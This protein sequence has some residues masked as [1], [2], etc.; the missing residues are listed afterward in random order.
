M[1]HITD[2]VREAQQGFAD[3]PLNRVDALVFSWLAN[4]RIPEECPQACTEQG[5]TIFELGGQR[6]TLG[7]VATVYDPSGTEELLRACALSPRFADITVSRCVDEWSQSTEH[8][9]SATTFLLPQGALIA[10]RA[11]DN[12]VVGWKE[13]LNMCFCPTIPSQE[14]ARAYVERV[15]AQTEDKLWLAGH[16]KGGNLAL[17]AA[18]FCPADVRSRIERCFVFDAPGLSKETAP[19]SHWEEV[20]PLVDRVV[21]EES[22]VGLLWDSHDVDPLLVRSDNKGILQHAPLSWRVRGD[23]FE[24]ATAIS[25]DAYRA[26]RR[27]TAWMETHTAAERER[28]VELLYDLVESTGEITAS[29]LL[30]S[31]SEGSLDIMLRRMDRFSGDDREFFQEMLGDLVATML[32]GPKPADPQ[33]PEESVQVASDTINDAEARFNSTQ[34]KLDALLGL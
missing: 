12:T 9:F 1:A 17:Y 28:F 2:Y 8:Q 15:A 31:V 11:T 34:A 20:V 5:T 3:K 7:L 29:G 27:L 13:N 26:E 21:A 32:L 6:S 4:L 25:Y 19:G 22:M 33:T 24:R 30:R 16:S 23:D 14:S 18:A 10:F